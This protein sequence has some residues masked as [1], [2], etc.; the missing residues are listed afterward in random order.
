M[1]N[2]K[3][4]TKQYIIHIAGSCFYKYNIV[5]RLLKTNYK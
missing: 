4:K 3:E 1:N 2:R 5:N